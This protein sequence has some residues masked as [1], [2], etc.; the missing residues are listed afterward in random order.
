[1]GPHS[2]NI[3]VSIC[4]FSMT[5]GR[6]GHMIHMRPVAAVPAICAIMTMVARTLNVSTSVHYIA[7]VRGTDNDR[8]IPY[9]NLMIP[10]GSNLIIFG[11]SDSKSSIIFQFPTNFPN[12]LFVPWKQSFI[13]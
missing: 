12:A 4:K 11:L 6:T 2:P 7:A 13:A 3:I 9:S 8:G 1:M 10:N 5:A